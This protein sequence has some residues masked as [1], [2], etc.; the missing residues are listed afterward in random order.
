[1]CHD[2]A[3]ATTIC[4][5]KAQR[6]VGEIWGTP[7]S[8]PS[9]SPMSSS[10]YGRTE[11]RPH[12]ALRSASRALPCGQWPPFRLSLAVFG[13]CRNPRLW[14]RSQP[15]SK[16]AAQSEGGH[17][18]RAPHSTYPKSCDTNAWTI[19]SPIAPATPLALA[20]FSNRLLCSWVLNASR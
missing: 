13:G 10:N 5:A 8:A 20:H 1:M 2:P 14:N 9:L 4:S 16:G 18:W 7:A 19:A 6:S 12:R 17:G 3:H 15:W 11:E